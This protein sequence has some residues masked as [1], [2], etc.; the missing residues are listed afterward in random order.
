MKKGEIRERREGERKRECLGL[1]VI[2]ESKTI[3][4]EVKNEFVDEPAVLLVEG[5]KLLNI[6]GGVTQHCSVHCL[7][8]INNIINHYWSSLA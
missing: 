7:R 6:F 4:L 5:L 8:V 1:F 3:P 2:R